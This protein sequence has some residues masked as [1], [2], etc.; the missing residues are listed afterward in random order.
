[1]NN[2]PIPQKRPTLLAS[3]ILIIIIFGVY[4]PGGEYQK[5]LHYYREQLYSNPPQVS[6]L[7]FPELKNAQLHLTIYFPR[8]VANFGER[9]IYFSIRYS[10]DEKDKNVENKVINSSRLWIYHGSGSENKDDGTLLLPYL[11]KDNTHVTGFDIGEIYPNSQVSGRIPVVSTS[12]ENIRIGSIWF[13]GEVKTQS[14]S[15]KEG[16]VVNKIIIREFGENVSWPLIEFNDPKASLHSLVETFL[17]PPWSNGV[18]PVLVLLVSWLIENCF[19]EEQKEPRLDRKGWGDVVKITMSVGGILLCVFSFA[20][21][22]LGLISILWLIFVFFVVV[23]VIFWFLKPCSNEDSHSSLSEQ[24]AP[25]S[26]FGTDEVSAAPGDLITQHPQILDKQHPPEEQPPSQG[27]D[28]E[29]QIIT[30]PPPAAWDTQTPTQQSSETKDT[31][32]NKDKRLKA[33]RRSF[34]DEYKRR[35][36]DEYDSGTEEQKRALL[37]RENLSRSYIDRWHTEFPQRPDFESSRLSSPDELSTAQATQVI[38]CPSCGQEN[39]SHNEFCY[40]CGTYLPK[41]NPA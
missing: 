35:I 32:Q 18:I 27:G 20:Y 6:S 4:Y 30:S 37:K 1:M 17:L 3:I 31:F 5:T 36:V 21:W 11:F 10:I 25:L 41:D 34:S 14:E 26:D 39:D 13:Q 2:L 40:N 23:L 12:R 19:Y 28:E 7:S 9:W 38:V 29:L 8:Y 24:K 33:K 15:E 22:S 16:K